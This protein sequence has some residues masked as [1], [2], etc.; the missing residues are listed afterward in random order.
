[1]SRPSSFSSSGSGSPSDP[2][3]GGPAGTPPGRRGRCGR[4]ASPGR[5][6]RG[7]A[8]SAPGLGVRSPRAGAPR[9]WG[10]AAG[11]AP[12]AAPRRE[13]HGPATSGE[14]GH[15]RGRPGSGRVFAFRFGR[16]V[17]WG[18]CGESLETGGRV[19]CGVC[20]LALDRAGGRHSWGSSM[21]KHLNK[22]ECGPG[23]PRRGPSL[24]P[25]PPGV[26]GRGADKANDRTRCVAGDGFDSTTNFTS[27]LPNSE[28]VI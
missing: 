15:L 3:V 27:Q 12:G 22:A 24:G 8:G 26:G 16:R 11:D 2:R 13:G 28:Q 20:G 10:G 7:P 23:Q 21:A 9:G 4:G 25:G 6:V 19:R 1:M 17:F 14:R 5:A 18:P